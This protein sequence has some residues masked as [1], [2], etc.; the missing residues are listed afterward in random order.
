LEDAV[1]KKQTMTA[2]DVER[3]FQ[4]IVAKAGDA[5]AE[6]VILREVVTPEGVR[7]LNKDLAPMSPQTA[8]AIVRKMIEIAHGGAVS[9]AE[10]VA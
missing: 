5:K 3:A 6:G 2:A 4:A 7:W 1:L 10:A 8:V 9:S